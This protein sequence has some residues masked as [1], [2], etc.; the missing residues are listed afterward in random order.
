MISP[1][2]GFCYQYD[3][4]DYDYG[5]SSTTLSPGRRRK[6]KSP[7]RL[8]GRH[9]SSQSRPRWRRDTEETEAELAL[10]SFGSVLRYQC[11]LAR[12]FWDPE[13]EEEYDERRMRCNWNNTWTQHD[14]L[15]ACIWTQCLYPPTPPPASRLASTWSGDPVDFYG[16]VSF[17]CEE[18]ELYFEWDREME[19]FNVTCLHGG[20]WDT[21]D[22]WPICL[23]S[24]YPCPPPSYSH[25]SLPPSC[26]LHD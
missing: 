2:A 26:E 17:V 15:D 13:L 14:S 25:Y 22:I 20:D 6:R 9:Q 24:E 5:T 19:E 21:P 18:E 16:N 4:G 12:R 8:R 10:R 3:S 1:T 23:P 7:G 11:G